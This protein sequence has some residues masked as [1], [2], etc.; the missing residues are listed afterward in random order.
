VASGTPEKVAKSP[1]S[2]T[3]RFLAE[4]LG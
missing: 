4:I 2:H 1:D 3:G